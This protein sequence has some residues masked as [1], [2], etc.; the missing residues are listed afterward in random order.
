MTA[1]LAKLLAAA[2]AAAAIGWGG[3]ALAVEGPTAYLPGVTVGQEVGI[4]PPP[5]YYFFDRNIILTGPVTNSAGNNKPVNVNAYLNVPYLIWSPNLKILGAQYTAFLSQPFA[6]QSV[7]ALGV[8][9]ASVGAFNTF[10]T[11]LSLSWD[12]AKPFYFS[13]TLLAYANDGDFVHQFSPAAGRQVISPTSI[14]TG[15]W[16]IEPEVGVTYL[17]NGWNA[18]AFFVFDINTDN[19]TTNYQSGNVFYLDW[20]AGKTIGKWTVGFGGAVAQQVNNDSI[21][22]VTQPNS[23]YQNVLI[24]PYVAYDFGPVNMS[25]KFQQSVHTVNGPSLS[26]Y[27]WQVAFPF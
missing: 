12:Y 13:F 24:G 20:S 3:P 7:N 22:G 19:T 27:Y 1:R 18:S 4:N 10:F 11:P 15:Y 14:A 9:N 2:G 21:A 26:E 25:L 23:E 5:G 8:D 17:Q 16:T 6:V